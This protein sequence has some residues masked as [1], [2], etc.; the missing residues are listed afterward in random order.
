MDELSAQ[1]L[2]YEPVHIE[3]LIGKKGKNQGNIRDVEVEK[4]KE[5]S[6]EDADIT[7]QLKH[8]FV[9]LLKQKEL[10]K[11]F[12]E[13]EN[14]LVQ[15]LTEMEY[16]GVKIDMAFLKDYSIQLDMEAKAA[17]Q[18]VFDCCGIRFNLASP[19]QLGEVLFEHLKL[20][21]KARKTK[22]GQ[23]ATGEDILVK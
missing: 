21:P 6:A 14:P 23:Y 12:N 9:P 5:Y 22:T 7:L 2:Q 4:I 13:V 19:K 1:Y 11:V 18:R 10:E 16:E 17:E 3:E 8:K 15:V 20:D